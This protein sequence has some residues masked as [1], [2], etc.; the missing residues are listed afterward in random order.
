MNCF[1]VSFLRQLSYVSTKTKENQGFGT[2]LSEQYS[3]ELQGTIICFSQ[4]VL[5]VVSNIA[6]DDSR[7]GAYQN[8]KKL[9]A[10]RSSSSNSSSFLYECTFFLVALYELLR[11]KSG[12]PFDGR[13]LAVKG[14]LE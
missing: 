5:S 14:L 1:S 8:C 10:M 4:V 2:Y 13:A 11:L 7:Y 6:Q 12:A 3:T 9:V